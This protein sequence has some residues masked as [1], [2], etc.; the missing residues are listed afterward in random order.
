MIIV[1]VFGHKKR[2]NGLLIDER[3]KRIHKF[4]LFNR[5]ALPGPSKNRR[6]NSEGLTLPPK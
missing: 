1:T 5:V 4:A 6:G 3:V 2:E